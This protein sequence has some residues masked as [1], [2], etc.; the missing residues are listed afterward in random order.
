MAAGRENQDER[1][2][3]RRGF[4]VTIGTAGLVVGLPLVHAALA[5][6]LHPEEGRAVA[7]VPCPVGGAQDLQ[8]VASSGKP[9]IIAAKC[10][11]CGKCV[12]LASRTFAMDA[13][14]EKAYVKNATGDAAATIAKAARAC[15]AAAI[16]IG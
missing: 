16:R 9:S 2:V 3:S 8:Q 11:G 10:V 1:P 12:R 14:T 5:G 15:P 13:K 6:T 7:G 4:I